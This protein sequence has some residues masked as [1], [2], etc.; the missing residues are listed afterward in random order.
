MSQ[1]SLPFPLAGG[2]EVSRGHMSGFEFIFSLFGLILGLAL[3]E[4]LGGLARALK[5]SH[6]V[7]IG[8]PTALLGL[9][10]SCDVVTFWMYGWAMQGQLP[11]GWPVMFGGFV[12][13]AIYYVAASLVFPDDPEGWSDLNAHFD[14]HRRKVIGGIFLCNIALIVTYGVLVDV[15]PFDLR[16]IV[17]TWSFFPAAAVAIWAKDRRVVIACLIW[18]IA[19]YPL[20]AVWH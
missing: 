7:R 2:E 8:W 12:V 10:V 18:L 16:R 6:K 19:T 9:F 20:S 3:A 14:K 13:T 5:A 4:G 11:L 17:I 1:V 15:P